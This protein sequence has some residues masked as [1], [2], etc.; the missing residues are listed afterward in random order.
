MPQNSFPGRI[1]VITGPMFSGKSEELVRRLKSALLSWRRV[2]YFKPDVDPLF[3]RSAVSQNT[4]TL[5]AQIVANTGELKEA[6]LPVIRD[7]EVIGIGE[8][9]FFD[10]SLVRLVQE[11]ARLN[12]HV[13]IAG[14]DT[15]FAGEPFQPMPDL[16][17]IADVVVKLTGE[18]AKCGEPAVHTQRISSSQELILLGSTDAYEARCRLCFE[19]NRDENGSEQLE[20]PTVA[21]R[22]SVYSDHIQISGDH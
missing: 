20:L 15:T 7:I 2:L 10:P 22:P 13:I 9:Q 14:V 4:A 8:A 21:G 5:N 6:L 12:K 3:C 16:L 19:P 17:A 18:C 1:E 11:L